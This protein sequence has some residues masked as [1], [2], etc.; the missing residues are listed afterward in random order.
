MRALRKSCRTRIER[1]ETVGGKRKADRM[2]LE[3]RREIVR[4]LI[5]RSI[6]EAYERG[7]LDRRLLIGR[8]EAYDRIR[9]N[10]ALLRRLRRRADPP[11]RL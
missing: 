8:D 1:G 6:R 7:R 4:C 3:T 9:R 2:F 10:L 11:T 5:V